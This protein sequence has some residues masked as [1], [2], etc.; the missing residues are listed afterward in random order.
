M[1]SDA[2]FTTIYRTK[3]ESDCNGEPHPGK[4]VVVGVQSAY[5]EDEHEG[6]KEPHRWMFGGTY[7]SANPGAKRGAHA[8]PMQ[9]QALEII[10]GV[11]TTLA[12]YV[13]VRAKADFALIRLS[14][15]KYEFDKIGRRLPGA[16]SNAAEPEPPKAG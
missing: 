11:A 14:P 9:T 12:D 8:C 5:V 1:K 16:Y 6:A 4:Y 10:I 2:T 13:H 15:F 3:I 7:A